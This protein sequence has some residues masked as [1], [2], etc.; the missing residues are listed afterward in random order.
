MTLNPV[1]SP[2]CSHFG[3]G[4]LWEGEYVDNFI[5][6]LLWRSDPNRILLFFYSQFLYSSVS[7]GPITVPIVIIVAML[8]HNKVSRS[9]PK[10]TGSIL[11]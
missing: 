6:Q 3:T 8:Q 10:F 7:N 2:Y 4:N 9:P 11:L 1:I 5:M